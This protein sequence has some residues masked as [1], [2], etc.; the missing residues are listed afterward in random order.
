MSIYV[1]KAKKTQ[2]KANFGASDVQLTLNALVDSQGNTIAMASFGEWGV[3]VIKQGAKI[4]IVKFDDITQN[5]DG[6]ATLD[7]AT[8]GRNILPITPYTGSSTG[9]SFNAGAEVIVTNDPLTVMSFGNLYNANTWALLQTF[10]TIPQ[11]TGGNAT[12]DN[13]LVRYAQALAMATG[14]ASINRTVIAGNA[15]ENISAGQL[16]YLKVSDGEWY[17]T[18]ADDSATINNVILGIAQGAGTDGNSITSGVLL[19]GLDSNQTGLTSNTKYYAS[20]TAGGI[21][22]SAGTTSLAVG[23]SRST[24]SL[25]F[26]PRYDKS[27]TNAQQDALDGATSPSATNPFLTAL[28]FVGAVIPYAGSSAPTGWLKCDGTAVSRTTYATLYALIGT[29]YGIGDNSTTFNLPDLRSRGVVGVGT[30][31]K[32]A[33]FSSRSSNVITATGLTSANNNEFQTGQAVTYHTSG[34][35]ITGLTNDTVYYVVRVTN[36]TFS[37]ATSMA[38]AVAGTVITLS[39]DGTGTQTFTQTLT[40]RTL[41]DT[42]GEE[43]HALT[44]SEIPAHTHTINHGTSSGGGSGIVSNGNAPDNQSNKT[45]YS[46]GSSSNHSVMNPFVALNYIIKY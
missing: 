39:G 38:N 44:S 15:G 46:T 27:V 1:V 8:N 32:V 3:V 4:E 35:V 45:T 29:T 40:A 7:V 33:T 5:G 20:N 2:L 22:T 31:T 19:F 17:K 12:A 41:G 30:G 26:K 25:L 10:T 42:G 34:S 16:V 43:N 11:T 24:T 36:T 6:S 21:S 28:D 23:V 9:E 37:L 18:D 14:T 13:E